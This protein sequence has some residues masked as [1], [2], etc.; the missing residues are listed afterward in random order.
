MGDVQR[1]ERALRVLKELTLVDELYLMF[2]AR[3]VFTKALT[4]KRLCEEQSNN[5]KYISL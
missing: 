5:A 3:E 1:Q 2:T 4:Q